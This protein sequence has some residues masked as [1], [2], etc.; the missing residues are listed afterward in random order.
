MFLSKLKIQGFK[1][2][3][4]KTELN[5]TDGVT[6]I[7]G[8]NGC[9]KT[10]IVDAI[11]WVLGEQKASTL[12]STKMEEVIFNG[13][14]K[15]KPLNFCEATLT[16]ENNKELLP[17]EYETLE[18]TRRYFR[19]G[20]S[21]YY[22]NKNQCRLKD[23]HEMFVDTGMSSGA[24]SVIELKMIE[25]ILS[26]NPTDRRTMIDEASGINNYNKQRAASTRRLISTKSDMER[27]YDIMSEVETNVKKLKLQMK[28]Y[29]RHKVLTEDLLASEILLHKKSIDLLDE[30]LNPLIESRKSMINSKDVLLTDLSKKEK[31]LDEAQNKFE[32]TRLKMELFQKNIKEIE[33]NI[34]K[35]NQ[36]IIVATEQVGH[37]NNRID[38]SN[39]EITTKTAQLSAIQIEIKSMEKKIS[40]LIPKIDKKQFDYNKLDENFQKLCVESDLIEKKITS[41]QDQHS[42][43]IN[44]IN[45]IK[46]NIDS[47][48]RLISHNKNLIK[49]HR[50]EVQE[51]QKLYNESKISLDKLKI[52]LSSE[53]KD[54]DK[55]SNEL[56]KNESSISKIEQNLISLENHKNKLS[57]DLLKYKNKLD[58][59]NKLITSKDGASNGNEYIIKK[60]DNYRKFILG[61]LEDLI[62]CPKNLVAPLSMAIGKFSDYLVINK[63]SEA[64]EIV[65]FYQSKKM[66]F[67]F[68]ILDQIPKSK[69]KI[70][71]DTLLA[72]IEFSP[73]LA[74]FLYNLIGDFRILNESDIS[75][76]KKNN[77][78]FSDSSKILSN[79]ILRVNPNKY[80]SA[81][82]T[83]HEILEIEQ[84]INK[85]SKVDLIKLDKEISKENDKK[86]RLI[87]SSLK[88]KELIKINEISLGD[89]KIEIE[90]Y[91]FLIKE[92]DNKQRAINVNL[93][94]LEKE[95]IGS[96]IKSKELNQQATNLNKELK[97][98]DREKIK[99]S[100]DS[101]K[102]KNKILESRQ[103]LERSKINLIEIINNKNSIN[104]RI[105]D[106]KQNEKEISNEITRYKEDVDKSKTLI[107]NLVESNNLLKK[108]LKEFYKK[109]KSLNKEVGSLQNSYSK[110]YQTFQSLQ[111]EI[112]EKRKVTDSSKDNLNDLNI[113]IEK[114]NSEI[115]IHKNSLS[116]ISGQNI[117]KESVEKFNSFNIEEIS[118]NINKIKLSI[119]RIGPI[120]MDVDSQHQAEIERFD[121]LNNQYNDLVESETYLQETISSLDKEARK[122]FTSTFKEIQKNFSK[123][124]NM[125][126]QGGE[127]S[128]ELKG[129]DVL[130]AE[131]II[132]ATPPGKSSQSLRMLSGGEKAI[133]AISLLFAI[134]LVKPSPFCILDEVDAPLDDINIKRFN[135]VIKQFSTNSQFI[136]VTHNKLTME[137]SDYLYGVTQQQ[138]GISKI[139]SVNLND[140]DERF[141][142]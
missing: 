111:L 58:F 141:L 29:E 52:N 23:I 101:S 57:K 118:N 94:I 90:K 113:K 20:D 13:T 132:K 64:K 79:G 46:N 96:A 30:K 3:P 38:Q 25:S 86:N 125:F 7:V 83:K 48:E 32:K 91:K 78:I 92:H 60:Q 120:N 74:D 22:I 142:V 54:K 68:I 28:R 1:S 137:A 140:I 41:F 53:K 4:D 80:E 67:N 71:T 87:S 55:N 134:Y 138:K 6:S 11:R 56:V 40:Q 61:R 31:K 88:I 8:P 116:E 103:K 122:L 117:S 75:T 98:L 102:A 108:E 39:K 72:K 51:A 66:S 119:D 15:K 130:D 112:K 70:S 82:Y 69:K 99:I 129:D 65:D 14:K 19:N 44:K 27:I 89:I 105:N 107:K 77:F 59:Y 123:T 21:E 34:I 9:G 81:M 97:D 47:N 100:R 84:K 114:I 136:I 124:Y 2:F 115:N 73:K 106:Y 5:F 49:N 62:S 43:I 45:L 139:V 42:Q 26:Q 135:E 18:I 131:I 110:E 12:R 17:I 50:N 133:T 104:N 10:N 121:F 76:N 109:E 24:Y 36:D 93:N 35:I 127:A 128:I 126:Y 95:I 16:I 63:L 37:S 33:D 85:I